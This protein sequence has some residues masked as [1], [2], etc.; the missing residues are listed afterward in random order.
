MAFNANNPSVAGE[1]ARM[2]SQASF[3]NGRGL[4]RR[5]RRFCTGGDRPA[6]TFLV[7]GDW[8]ALCLAHPS[9][10]TRNAIQVYLNSLQ[11][12]LFDNLSQESRLVQQMIGM[13]FRPAD[14]FWVHKTIDG[15]CAWEG[16]MFTPDT[17]NVL[18]ERVGAKHINH[19]LAFYSELLDSSLDE[20]GRAAMDHWSSTDRQPVEEVDFASAI[21]AH[22]DEQQGQ[23]QEIVDMYRRSKEAWSHVLGE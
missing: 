7:V 9:K 11:H 5:L 2:L 17:F 23:F 15:R 13:G 8:L 3:D 1:F 19:Y 6:T 20:L 14:K 12:H 18:I 21:I 22:L 16:V 10:E 4:T